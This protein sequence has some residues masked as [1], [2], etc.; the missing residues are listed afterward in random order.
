MPPESNVEE[1]AKKPKNNEHNVIKH[2]LNCLV[3]DKR[4]VDW[5]KMLFEESFF[6]SNDAK[7]FS[8]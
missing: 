8:L 6:S 4:V 7:N 1:M 2:G 3:I 5:Q